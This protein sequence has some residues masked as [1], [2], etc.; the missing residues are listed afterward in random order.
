MCAACSR[1]QNIACEI[2]E[3]SDKADADAVHCTPPKADRIHRRNLA[4]L[5]RR[6]RSFFLITR[7]VPLR[8]ELGRAL[9]ASKS[10]FDHLQ[11]RKDEVMGDLRECLEQF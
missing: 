3:A 5:I 11:R 2:S 1:G 7:F 6:R 8:T 10:F 4:T 9:D